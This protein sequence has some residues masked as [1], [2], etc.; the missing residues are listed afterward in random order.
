[1]K[2]ISA[3]SK[4]RVIP[5]GDNLKEEKTHST[6]LVV[7]L[8]TLL[9]GLYSII[10]FFG[11]SEEMLDALYPPRMANFLLYAAIFASTFKQEFFQK[12]YNKIMM[13]G[14]TVSGIAI[15]Y[16]ILIS[17]EGDYSHDMYFAALMGLIFMSFTWSYLP[18][19]YPFIMSVGLIAT[20]AIIKIYFHQ[21]T[22]GGKS[23]AF[24]GQVFYMINVL[25]IASIAQI[26]RD[27]LIKKNIL[28]KQ[29]F[30]DNLLV[31]T[32]E[33]KKQKSRANLDMLTG[34]PNRR[35]ITKL[36]NKAVK[37]AEENNTHLTL[38]FIDLN[39]F[40]KINDTYGH[41]SGDK[42][43]EVTAKRLKTTIKKDDYVARLGGDEFLIAIKTD[44]Y[45]DLY[46]KNL[47]NRLRAVITSHIAFNGCKLHVG[48]SIGIANYP[49]DG[50]DTE[51][52]IKVAD[53]RMYVDKQH[54]KKEMP[55][56]LSQSLI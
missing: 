52:L 28:L 53:N 23:I 22:S 14:Y 38:V 39:G 26:I 11:L 35:H 30:E 37:V 21:D 2:L 16:A 51:A 40:K 3:I 20:F 29:T 12:H 15:S 36:L 48:T 43:L 47:C 8:G 1:M 13:S 46:I 33:A 54:S 6:R 31:K 34:I 5:F 49:E 42:V 9:Y 55:A 19:K 18:I 4:Y 44:N 24:I 41:N 27:I 10:D 56:A 45:S 17:Q 7:L 25:I 32:Q 50:K